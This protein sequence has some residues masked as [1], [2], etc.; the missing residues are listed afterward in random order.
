MC[1]FRVC[2]CRVNS[3]PYIVYCMCQFRV[4]TC[5]VNSGPYIMYVPCQFRAMYVPCQFRPYLFVYHCCVLKFFLCPSCHQKTWGRCRGS[6][7][8]QH[9]NRVVP[10]KPYCNPVIDV[11]RLCYEAA[12]EPDRYIAC[13]FSYF[14]MFLRIFVCCLYNACVGTVPIPCRAKFRACLAYIVYCM[15]QFRVCTCRVNSGP[16]IVYCMCQIPCMY[17]PCQFRPLYCVG[18]VLRTCR[19]NSVLMPC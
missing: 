11:R 9:V 12:A 13:V 17:V 3:G 18:A 19:A 16:Y 6:Y 1:Q 5:R 10:V 14:R 15:C 4:C 2:T 7:I 8:A